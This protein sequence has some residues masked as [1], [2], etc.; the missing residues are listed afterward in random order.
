MVRNTTTLHF[1]PW[2]RTRKSHSWYVLTLII[3]EYNSWG[4]ICFLS[5]T[6]W[7]LR[8]RFSFSYSLYRRKYFCTNLCIIFHVLSDICV[9]TIFILSLT[10]ICCSLRFEFILNIVAAVLQVIELI[11]AV[12]TLIQL[13]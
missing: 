1:V 12:I 4:V 7:K 9:C 5:R 6:T 10:L 8:T 11:F 3:C 2:P 13:P